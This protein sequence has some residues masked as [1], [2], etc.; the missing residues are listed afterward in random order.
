MHIQME[1]F[2]NKPRRVDLAFALGAVL[3]VFGSQAQAQV[4]DIGIL[5]DN[6]KLLITGGVSQVEGAGGGG[7]AAW[8]LITGYETRD[9]VGVTVHE[10]YIPLNDFTL[11]APGIAVGFYDR[12]ELSYAANLFTLDNENL[13]PGGLH[14]GRTLQQDVF[15]A[16]VRVVGD[17]IYD[18]DSFLPQIAIGVQH[19]RSH[20]P[21]VLG[22]LGARDQ[23]GTDFYLVG[24]K[25]FAEYSLFTSA[26]IRLTKANQFGLLGF[27]GPGG[28]NYKP[29]FEGSIAYLFSKRFAVGAEYRTKPSNITKFAG[30]L[31]VTREENAFDLF[32]A[33]F[34]N[35]NVSLTA[36]YVDLGHIANVSLAPLGLDKTLEPRRQNGAYLSLQIAL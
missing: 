10:T 5:S 30:V 23:N 17:A 9:S 2:M 15:G 13:A 11:H 14:K 27:G 19:K 6:G 16:K 20:D 26:A 18:Q 36:G 1:D 34:L 4:K 33:Y 21:D 3:S 29:Q 32:A 35:K 28:N 24:S 22:A 7:L 31:P 25:L 12:V 8:S